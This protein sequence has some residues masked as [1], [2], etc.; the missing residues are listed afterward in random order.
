MGTP[1]ANRSV[2]QLFHSRVER[3]LLV[4]H[5]LHEFRD[6]ICEVHI[7]LNLT[8]TFAGLLGNNLAGFLAQK[9]PVKLVRIAS[10]VL[11]AAIGILAAFEYT[12]T[13][14]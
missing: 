12:P 6:Q 1:W 9:I 7:P 14:L 4:I 8:R 3:C 13:E 5:H 11:F 2:A 10:A